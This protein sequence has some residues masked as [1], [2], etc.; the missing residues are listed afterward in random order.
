MHKQIVIITKYFVPHS[1]VDTNAVYDLI[2]KFLAEDPKIDI[3]V[4]TS[5]SNYKIDIKLREFKEQILKRITVHQTKTIKIQTKS[6]IK[7]FIFGLIE[8]FQLIKKAKSLNIDTIITLSN[9]PLIIA[10]ANNLLKSKKLFYWSFDLYP[11]AFVSDG[12]LSKR[13]KSYQLL[14]RLTYKFSP[15]GI[16]ALGENQFRYLKNKFRSNSIKKILLPCGIHNIKKAK[17]EP[18]WHHK[19]KINIAYVGNIG[20]AH[21]AKFLKNFIRVAEKYDQI[22]F[23]LT[24]YGFHAEEIRQYI[25]ENGFQ[26]VRF[27]ESVPQNEMG[28]IDIHLVSLNESWTHVSVPSKAVSAVCSGSAIWFNGSKESDTWK[29]FETCSYYSNN[30]ISEIEEN[31]SQLNHLD[32]IRKKERA[33]NIALQLIELECQSIKELIQEF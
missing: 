21:S 28:Y 10:L 25:S 15:Y 30:N 26:N 1:N 7:K 22:H 29:M 20:K 31:L 27:T 13:S 32:V 23:F 12:I 2:V 4:V 14:D 9:P 11:D 6:N 33:N 24:I 19:D 18:K 5:G 16:L 17:V 3:H 8:G